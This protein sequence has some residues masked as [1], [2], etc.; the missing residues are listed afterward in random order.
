MNN[1][2]PSRPAERRR[3]VI[4][5]DR[6]IPRRYFLLAGTGIVVLFA[7]AFG[8]IVWA[9]WSSARKDS[10]SDEELSRLTALASEHGWTYKAQDAGGVDRYE[11]VAP[12]P[13]LSSG[14]SA[15]DDIEGR[16]RGRSIR[17]FEYRDE[18]TVRSAGPKRL[19][20]KTT[21]YSVFS[22]TTPGTVPRAVVHEP[23]DLDGKFA[24]GKLENFLRTDPRADGVPLRFDKGELI[25]WFE[26]RLRPTDVLPKLNFLCDVLEHTPTSVWD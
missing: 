9:S 15:W 22:V 11:G 2:A 13:N 17:C 21:Y 10:R 18:E 19:D 6:E 25:T 12:F 26:G 3:V 1:E 20:T 16:H 8:G 5:N 4:V 14:L 7:G 24:N 23:G